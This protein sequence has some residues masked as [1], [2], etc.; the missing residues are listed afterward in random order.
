M[1]ARPLRG[2]VDQGAGAGNPEPADQGPKPKENHPDATRTNTVT[3]A[4]SPIWDALLNAAAYLVEKY[5]E[6]ADEDHPA[7]ADQSPKPEPERPDATRTQTAPDPDPRP[8]PEPTTAR[9]PRAGLADHGRDNP[10]PAP[11]DPKPKKNHPDATRTNTVTGA[12]SPIWDA[13]LDAAAYLVEK[14]PEL[15]DEDHLAPADQHPKPKENRP[16]A[17]LTQTAPTPDPTQE[18]KMPPAASARGLANHDAGNPA[19]A[20][21]SPKTG[22]GTPGRYPH[23]PPPEHPRPNAPPR[24]RRAP[25]P[26]GKNDRP[27]PTRGLGG[28][29]RGQPVPGG[30]KPKTGRNPGGDGVLEMTIPGALLA[31]PS[32]D[33]CAR[34]L[35]EVRQRLSDP[36][37]GEDELWSYIY[38]VM[39]RP[40]L[41]GAVRGGTGNLRA[42]LPLPSGRETF[43]VFARAG[44]ELMSLH[45]DY[46]R[47]PESTVP[48]LEIAYE[49]DREEDGSWEEL[50]I[51]REG[52]RWER[53]KGEDGKWGD[54]LTR[55][56]IN[57]RAS[58][59]R[60]PPAAHEYRVAGLS[61]LQW[62]VSQETFGEGD[63]EDPNL[64]PRWRNDPYGLVAH[65]RRL[66]YVGTR[67]AEIMEGLPPSPAACEEGDG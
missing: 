6:L 44:E 63:E 57:D 35:D 23:P 60:I 21:Q 64:D 31:A 38:G 2:L 37:I 40:R 39:P 17:T 53:V 41:A 52:M 22:R 32:D 29:R 34:L 3:G 46:D 56:K 18:I 16:D 33:G 10:A 19:P 25:P 61:P 9:R 14:Y 24:A 11:P 5:P 20:G 55:L 15:A 12:A 13:L 50:R 65:L 43:G 26:G 58:L 45:A 51:P 8:R 49:E 27:P 28:P 59:A 66:T 62:A 48:R 36:G 4:A 7:P 67:T 30:P 54:D 1:T 47:A 42:P